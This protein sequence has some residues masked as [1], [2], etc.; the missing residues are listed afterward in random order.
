MYLS[1]YIL[2]EGFEKELFVSMQE[3][4]NQFEF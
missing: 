2:F 1:I 3:L 4:T